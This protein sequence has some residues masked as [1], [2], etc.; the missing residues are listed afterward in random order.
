MIWT[1]FSVEVISPVH[2]LNSQFSF[3]I[4]VNSIVVPVENNESSVNSPSILFSMVPCPLIINDNKFN[5]SKTAVISFDEFTTIVI[6]LSV[7]VM[8]PFHSTNFQP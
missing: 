6:G 4:A 8:S 1:G 3:G 2:S 5:F 7:L